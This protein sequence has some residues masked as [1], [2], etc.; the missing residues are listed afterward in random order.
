M[1]IPLMVGKCVMTLLMVYEYECGTKLNSS[2]EH[3]G[4]PFNVHTSDLNSCLV[5]LRNLLSFSSLT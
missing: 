1:E 4:Q 3:G 2:F 5:F